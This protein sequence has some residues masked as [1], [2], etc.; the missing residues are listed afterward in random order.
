MPQQTKKARGCQKAINE[1][2]PIEDGGKKCDD[3]ASTSSAACDDED[4]VRRSSRKRTKSKWLEGMQTSFG[5][6]K[7]KIQKLGGSDDK[8][9]K[10]VSKSTPNAATQKTSPKAEVITSKLTAVLRTGNK[11]MERTLSKRTDSIPASIS[12]P[13]RKM[14]VDESG[15]QSYLSERGSSAAGEAE[16]NFEKMSETV[17]C[18]E[19]ITGDVIEKNNDLKTVHSQMQNRIPSVVTAGSGTDVKSLED[20]TSAAVTLAAMQ[21]ETVLQ[22]CDTPA[23]LL[24]DECEDGEQKDCCVEIISVAPMTSTGVVTEGIRPVISESSVE[25]GTS[26]YTELTTASQTVINS[27]LANENTGIRHGEGS[28]YGANSGLT[29]LTAAATA[30][31]PP[32]LMGTART[33]SGQ[34][35]LVIPSSQITIQRSDETVP[36]F[37]V[38]ESVK[39][40][41]S[42]PNAV[43]TIPEQTLSGPSNQM[44]TVQW[45]S[46]VMDTDINSQPQQA[47]E[48]DTRSEEM[49]IAEVE[50]QNLGGSEKLE[51]DIFVETVNIDELPDEVASIIKNYS[52]PNISRPEGVPDSLGR[53][54]KVFKINK[55]EGQQIVKNLQQKTGASS[56]TLVYDKD[57]NCIK[58][59]QRF[60][61]NVQSSEE[62]LLKC[63]NCEYI[64]D[65]RANWYKHKK[66]H[67][68]F[69]PHRCNLCDYRATTSSNLKRHHDTH[70]G[71]RMFACKVEGCT[72]KFKQKIHLDRHIR[73]KHMVK[74]VC[75]GL[76]DYTCA[77]ENP[78]LRIHMLRKHSEKPQGE[79]KPVITLK[80]G[81]CSFETTSRKDLQQHLKFHRKGP[82]LKLFCEHCSFVTDCQSRLNRHLLIHTKQKPFKCG[83]CEYRASQKEHV[84]RHMRMRHKLDIHKAKQVVIK[85]L[86]EENWSGQDSLGDETLSSQG[87]VV[88][89]VATGHESLLQDGEEMTE[90]LADEVTRTEEM[91]SK[92]E[93]KSVILTSDEVG[94]CSYQVSSDELLIMADKIETVEMVEETGQVVDGS[95]EMCVT[96]DNVNKGEECLTIGAIEPDAVSVCN[97]EYPKDQVVVGTSEPEVVSSSPVVTVGSNSDENI[98]LFISPGVVEAAQNSDSEPKTKPRTVY[99]KKKYAKSDFSTVPKIFNC[100]YCT[101]RFAKLLNLYKHVHGQHATIHPMAPEGMFGCVVCDFKTPQKK[102]LLIHMRRHNPESDPEETPNMIFSCVLCQYCTPKRRNLY[103][104]LKKKHKISLLVNKDGTAKCVVDENGPV[105]VVSAPTED[106]AVDMNGQQ[107]ALAVEEPR[108]SATAKV[109]NVSDLAHSLIQPKV[110]PTGGVVQEMNIQTVEVVM[111]DI[112]I[113]VSA[114][115]DDAAVAIEGLQALAEQTISTHSEVA[116]RE[117]G[118]TQTHSDI[119]VEGAVDV[120]HQNIELSSEQVMELSTGDYIE[121]DGEMY[122]VEFTPEEGAGAEAIAIKTE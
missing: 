26:I 24:P 52:A 44:P 84:I 103:W 13:A 56:T 8:M 63:S 112:K 4:G 94:K 31:I 18:V 86:N 46:L 81:S 22:T 65:K 117:S 119:L 68:S 105:S 87:A 29:I 116:V 50:Q 109:I 99:K 113:E 90:V 12:I 73:Y 118:S 34:E 92:S 54:F 106:G 51:K 7:A 6:P 101:M 102:A 95:K 59:P 71:L 91:E 39:L 64:T 41:D 78:D 66:K 37:A 114:E 53:Q 17:C 98:E 25:P 72:A 43:Q 3:S 35:T 48:Q 30:D 49:L 62:A 107:V 67:E 74:Q 120:A 76:C 10:I 121:I 104:H 45:Q 21:V 2:K 32:H 58:L 97:V 69:R 79:E 14:S 40:S 57:G 88:R 100:E 70:S 47:G 110:T 11:E 108:G 80:C 9:Q 19:E 23:H 15:Q 38:L 36:G 28:Q 83:V 1:K 5:T 82:E 55:T 42:L 96:G 27:I 115:D 93:Q 122:K 89:D 33:I 77:L 75:C 16:K 60:L 85:P 20:A 61:Q 111:S